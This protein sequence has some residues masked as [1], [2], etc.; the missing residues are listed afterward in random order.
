MKRKNR[1]MHH[2][3]QN[4]RTSWTRILVGCALWTVGITAI[5]T[6]SRAAFQFEADHSLPLVYMN[7]VVDAGSAADPVHQQGL[8]QLSANMLLKGSLKNSKNL[9]FEKLARIGGQLEV[10]VRSEGTI[11]RGAVLAEHV[12]TFLN[13]FTEAL[14]QPSFDASELA[15]LKREIQGQLLD[16]KNNDRAFAGYEFGRFFYHGH[17]YGNP[18]AGTRQGIQAVSLDDVRQFY[19][20]YFGAQ[21]TRFF[22]SGSADSA[23]IKRWFTNI[24]TQLNSMHPD[25]RA[26][27]AVT[28]MAAH[29]E[30]RVLIIDKDKSTQSQV[31]IGLQGFRPETANIYAATVAN[32]VFG[33]P[34]FTSRLMTEIRVKRGWTYS[35]GS[36]FKF[37]RQPKHFQMAMFPKTQD[38]VPAIKLALEL[39]EDWRT[40]GISDTEFNFAKTGLINNAPFELDTSRKRLENAVSEYLSNFPK[41]FHKEIG[42]NIGLVQKADLLPTIKNAFPSRGITIVIV[43][44]AKALKP[45]LAK[46]PGFGNI[47]VRPYL[48][49]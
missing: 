35:T 49:D 33:G 31:I 1:T 24:Q 41:D 19:A 25:A 27:A 43:G 38:V 15:L 14:T 28:P 23:K 42:A 17:A 9:F 47:T 32:H 37:A 16:L 45:E 7:V 10:D 8:A 34:T 21:S 30:N 20:R 4:I 6:P 5:A 48:Q 18:E 3:T 12:D 11:V 44:N 39:L 13:L 46:L 22:G 40:K 36:S 29:A 2:K 26:A